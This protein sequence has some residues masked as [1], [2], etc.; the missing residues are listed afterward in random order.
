M[1]PK[2]PFNKLSITK[3]QSRMQTANNLKHSTPFFG[4]HTYL[5]IY[6]LFCKLFFLINRKSKPFNSNSPLAALKRLGSS[7][8]LTSADCL[9]Q[10][11][12]LPP[13]AQPRRSSSK[14]KRTSRIFLNI[15]PKPFLP[16]SA[17]LV[18]SGTVT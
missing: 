11:F 5:K 2:Y 17:I 16:F 18:R 7:G 13:T 8:T 10:A 6:A 14:E 1:P 9:L 3:M 4:A 15:T 12:G